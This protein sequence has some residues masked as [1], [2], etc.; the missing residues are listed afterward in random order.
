MSEIDTRAKRLDD[1]TV[2]IA[3]IV[4][5][6]WAASYVADMAMTT[7]EAPA[8]VQALM[9]VVAGGLFA[10][11]FVKSSQPYPSPPPSPPQPKEADPNG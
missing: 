2:V 4:T 5:V 11:P 3:W 10:R 8:G 7:Y 6:L 9:V 1:I